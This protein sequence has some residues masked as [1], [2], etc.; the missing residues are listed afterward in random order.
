MLACPMTPQMPIILLT[1]PKAAARSFA[2][3]LAGLAAELVISPVQRIEKTRFEMPERITGAIFTSG[4]AVAMMD[5]QD[6]PAWCVGAAT[7]RAA[8]DKGW[9]AISADGDAEGLLRRILADAPPAPLAHFRGEFARGD[10]ARRLTEAGLTTHDIIVYRQ[11]S[12]RLSQTARG[13]LGGKSPVIVPLFSPRSAVQLVQQ[14]PF[15][16]P[17]YVVAISNAVAAEAAALA[18]RQ[19]HVAARPDAAAMVAAIRQVANAA[20]GIESGGNST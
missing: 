16:A 5:G 15:S 17:L 2:A 18:A 3:Q 7:A 20:Y 6:L 8:R 1:R 4:N 11:S 14:G 12:K 10:L 9:R 19:V 13:Y